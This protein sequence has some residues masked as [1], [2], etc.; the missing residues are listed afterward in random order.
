MIFTLYTQSGSSDLRFET[1]TLYSA[2]SN[3]DYNSEHTLKCY[4]NSI[5]STIILTIDGNEV[6]NKTD[7]VFTYPNSNSSI[8][9]GNSI[10][11]NENNAMNIN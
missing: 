7:I 3:M 1:Q 11:E 5:D 2:T 6:F 4:V 9:I 8:T 10:G